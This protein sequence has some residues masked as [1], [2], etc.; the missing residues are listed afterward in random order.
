VF[1]A[2][3][4]LDKGDVQKAGEVAYGSMVQSAKALVKE[5]YYDVPDDP[6]VILNEFRT[7][8]YDTKVFWDNYAHGKFGQYIFRAHEVSANPYTPE[9]AHRRVE[10]AQLVVEA[11]YSAYAKIMAAKPTAIKP[12]SLKTPGAN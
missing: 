10:E 1:E 12:I 11:A 5:E 4:L 3:V 6:N 7:R 2:Q 9:E 8:L